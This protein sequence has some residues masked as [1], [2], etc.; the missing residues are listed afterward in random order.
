MVYRLV[1]S[2]TGAPV[3]T[4]AGTTTCGTRAAGE[5]V[6]DPVKMRRPQSITR[7]AWER[8]NLALIFHTSLINCDPTSVEIVATQS[9]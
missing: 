8:K 6:T 1:D 7:D 9:W 2:K 5:F 4:L 3:I